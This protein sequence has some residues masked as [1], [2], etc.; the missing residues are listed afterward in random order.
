[1][2]NINGIIGYNN[3][4]SNIN[5]ILAAYGNDVIDVATGL[6]Y[7]L[8]L[9]S[10]N[11]VDFAV[12]LERVF[13][14]NYSAL[15]KT[16]DGTSWTTTHVSRAPIGKYQKPFKSRMYLGYCS[17][18]DPQAPQ[19][20]NNTVVSYP[21][22]VFHSDPYIGGKL[23]WGLEWGRAGVF[24]LNDPSYTDKSFFKVDSI[25]GYPV[26]QDFKENNIKV[27]DP[28][29]LT[30]FADPNQKNI[31]L[32]H[33][34]PSP[35]VLKLTSTASVSDDSNFWVGSNWFDVGAGDGD[36]IYGFGENSDRLLIFKL[37]SL[38]FYTGSELRQVRD[39][40]GTS[41]QRSV[42]NKGGYTYYFHGSDPLISGIYRYD[43]NYSIKVSKAIDPFIK[44]M[45]TSNYSEVVAWQE[46]EELR[47]YIGDISNTNYNISMTNAVVS[48]H[49]GTG[50]WDVSPIADVIK[51]ATRYISSNQQSYYT[52]TNDDQVL[53]MGTGHNHNG[54][55]IR[56]ELE[57]KPY[58]PSG[59]DII[60]K[61]TALQIIGRGTKGV[62][63][64]YKGWNN[65]TKID[66]QWKSLGELQ[67]DKTE[68][69]IPEEVSTASGFQ[70][71]YEETGSNE[72]DIYIEKSTM[73]YRPQRKRVI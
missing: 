24:G 71:D 49:T 10:S 20:A 39:A 43:G 33:S 68:L 42:I 55:P 14:Q 32:V 21:S 5:K 25:H 44:G 48:F 35:F 6:G 51:C 2:A 8:N 46:G 69:F 36:Q 38:W 66:N 67:D 57:T 19:D 47:W 61:F 29:I 15:P 50:A 40:P 1:M 45:S 3:I 7:G 60:N 58:Y 64:K 12:F 16:F 17:F 18:P 4:T 37:L 65:P 41:S 23:T 73:F 72:N 11:K 28:L 52:G 56:M 22:R 54:N 63:V 59:T 53:K 13:L 30:D 34:I 62:K 31:F 27:G 70:L 26:V 9:N